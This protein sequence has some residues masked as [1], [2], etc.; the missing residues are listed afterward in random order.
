LNRFGRNTI[1]QDRAFWRDF[2]LEQFKSPVFLLVFM[3]GFVYGI[4]GSPTDAMI[5]FSFLLIN[6][7]I[8]F[9][10]EWRFRGAERKLKMLMPG[11]SRVVRGGSISML[12]NDALV[13]GDIVKLRLGDIVPADLRII[14]ERGLATD[15]SVL[16]GETGHSV[17]S[18]LP[19][20][21]LDAT[22]KKV[23]NILFMN[24]AVVSG[25]AEAVVIATGE[26]THL[27]RLS[28]N[29]KKKFGLSLYEMEVIGFS[30]TV[31]KIVALLVALTIFLKL[32][33]SGTE[34]FFDFFIFYLALTVSL[35][36]EAL[37]LVT[38]FALSRGSMKLAKKSVVVKRLNAVEDLGN[39]EI[40]CTDK[41]GVLTENK[42]LLERIFS[43]QGKKCF[44]L[45]IA[46]SS[47]LKDGSFETAFD[48]ALFNQEY[49]LA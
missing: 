10:H 41:T 21:I 31:F 36:P 30:K 35:L 13:P 23:S 44:K 47:F 4:I 26:E 37:S 9:L 43:C 22:Q 7:G 24:T 33:F 45:A 40:L 29:V 14:E 15:E 8:A 32:V 1:V 2:L 5:V 20:D 6:L 38:A 12:D 28:L 3:M 18:A 25:S 48:E 11:K 42:L 34:D 17:K 49:S 27:G 46:G 19:L 16:T 39:I